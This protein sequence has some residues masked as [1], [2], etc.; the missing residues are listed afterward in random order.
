[1]AN[2]QKYFEKF[3]DKIK[4]GYNY[5]ENLKE[6]RDILLDNLRDN[7]DISFEYFNQ[8]SYGMRTGVKP[9]D[10][11]YDIDVGLI[12]EENDDVSFDVPYELKKKVYNALQHPNRAVKIKRPCVTVQYSSN[13]TE[14]YHVDF[15]IYKKKQD[16]SFLFAR[17]R[18]PDDEEHRWEAANPK[19]L[20]HLIKEKFENE[21]ERKQYRRCIRALKRW[22]SNRLNHK[23]LPSI[24]I[25]VAA[26]RYFEPKFYGSEQL[27]PNDVDA[28]I[29][30]LDKLHDCV[31]SKNLI[32]PTQPYSNLLCNLTDNQSK[33]L[34]SKIKKLKDDLEDSKD[35][36]RSQVDACKKMRKYFGQ[37][38]PVPEGTNLSTEQ[39]IEEKFALSKEMKALSLS[40]RISS[41][42]KL[43]SSILSR[44]DR[45][46]QTVP[47]GRDLEF[48]VDNHNEFMG[49]EF[50]WKVLNVGEEAERRGIRGQIEKG[51]IYKKE[52]SDFIGEHY[53][54]CYAVR[55]GVCIARETIEVPIR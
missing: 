45:E 35:I 40:L 10:G 13:G 17:G 3:S 21:G 51:G 50:Y 20:V 1:M 54:E 55:D 34:R 19:E 26:Y 44:F 23:N 24:A 12:F 42:P 49:C 39:F 48:T 36:N 28:L 4:T 31:L 14:K 25:T 2:I 22:K 37:D 46:L 9:I 5:H 52:H 8:G 27:L 41:Y 18:S 15:A 11:D 33:D 32:L 7:L 43:L 16:G 30:L 29:Y 53:V 38:F 47:I 6:K